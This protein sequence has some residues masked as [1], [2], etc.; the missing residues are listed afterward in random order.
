MVNNIIIFL[1]PV[2]LLTLTP[3]VDT[4]L[5]IRNTTRGGFWDGATTSL[6]ICSGLFFHAIIS[7]VGISVLI[8]QS[9]M[10]F[11]FLK[12]AGATYLIFLGTI[13]L[14]DAI[15]GN[16]NLSDKATTKTPDEFIAKRSFKEGLF[17]N[18]L[19][20]KAIVFYMAFLPQFIDPLKPALFQTFFLAGLHFIIAMVWQVLLASMISRAK[21]LLEKKIIKKSLN[22]ITGI[23]MIFFG[24]GLIID[25]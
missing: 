10:A 12:I 1:I 11:S 17:C 9:T 24:A 19:N 7:A 21:A 8:L 22:A 15:K 2:T 13:S 18:I 5:V 6:G 20:P 14:K 25:N 16:Y 23:V 4:M 3:G